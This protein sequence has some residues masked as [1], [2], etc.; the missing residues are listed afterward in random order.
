MIAGRKSLPLRLLF[1]NGTNHDD[2]K[3]TLKKL[4]QQ[5]GH[6]FTYYK[7]TTLLPIGNKERK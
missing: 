2:E 5:C 4:T 7:Q 3:S 6:K 1:D